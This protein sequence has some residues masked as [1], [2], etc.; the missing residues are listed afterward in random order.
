MGTS[1]GLVAKKVCNIATWLPVSTIYL[2]VA[3]KTPLKLILLHENGT[4]KMHV[5]TRILYTLITEH[6][7]LSMWLTSLQNYFVCK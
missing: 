4:L 7:I 5:I 6:S 1:T 3:L 2:R